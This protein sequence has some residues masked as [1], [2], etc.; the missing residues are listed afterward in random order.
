MKTGF[1]KTVLAKIKN[2]LRL[3]KK[4]RK[5]EKKLCIGEP[6]GFKHIEIWG[7]RPLLGETPVVVEEVESEWEDTE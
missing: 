6:F 5:E 4:K 2:L 7:A 1:W 3:E